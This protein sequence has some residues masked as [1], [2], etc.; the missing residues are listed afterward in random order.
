MTFL[1]NS[2][3]RYITA[4]RITTS[5]LILKNGINKKYLK[6]L[7]KIYTAEAYLS[8]SAKLPLDIENFG[9]NLFSAVCAVKQKPLCFSV[10]ANGN[11]LINKN[12]LTVLLLTL[13]QK[14]R[15]I[16]IKT[17]ENMI[18][19]DFKGNLKKCILPL[20]KLNGYFFLT[21]QNGKFIIPA[22][23]TKENSVPFYK[24]LEYFYDRFS[25]LNLFF[26]NL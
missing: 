14:C 6:N 15:E 4:L 7:C 11:Y 26:R 16:H 13:S 24:T 22:Q 9:L 17:A 12:I 23:K 3:E 18:I 10:N 19:I 20:K 5:L 2:R 25:P 21:G 1:P 8:Q